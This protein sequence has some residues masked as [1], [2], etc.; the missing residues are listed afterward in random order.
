MLAVRVHVHVIT[1]SCCLEAPIPEAWPSLVH[2]VLALGTLVTAV[3]P[4][5]TATL[6]AQGTR[7]WRGIELT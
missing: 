4:R 1:H 7:G 2:P 6:Y 5:L 3:P